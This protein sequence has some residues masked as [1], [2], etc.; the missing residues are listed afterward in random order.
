MVPVGEQNVKKE[1]NKLHMSGREV[2]MFTMKVVPQ[3]I[4][5]C[6]S[7]QQFGAEDIDLFLLHQGS[8][9]IV[10]NMTKELGLPKERV[11]FAAGKMGNT[12]SSSIP[13]MLEKHIAPSHDRILISGFGVGL[14]WATMLLSKADLN[15]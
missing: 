7:S 5:E 9:Y 6:L 15:Q 12:V 13:F 10:E 1:T 14:S 8:L 3:Q 11:P 2:F 4:Q